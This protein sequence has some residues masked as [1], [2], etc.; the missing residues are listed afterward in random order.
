MRMNTC[1]RAIL[2]GFEALVTVATFPAVCA[3]ADKT[4]LDGTAWTLT[5]LADRALVPGATVTLR[6]E[7]GR[8]LGSDGCNR[9]TAP[10]SISGSTLQ[11]GPN[12]AS[13]QMACPPPLMQQAEAFANAL[14]RTRSYRIA[15][16]KLDLLTADGAATATF[17]AQSTTLAG[18]AWLVTGYNNGKQA[19]VSV[20][21]D[22]S[23]TMAFSSDGKV[24]GSAGCN[25][26][27]A[28]CAFD[29]AKLTISPA[30]TTRKMCAQLERIMEQEQQ[31]LKALESVATARFEGDRLEL[32]T[33]DGALAMTLEREA[34]QR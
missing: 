13:T 27:T 31:F 2:V 20:L 23:L 12:G 29:G 24:T 7:G 1:I 9:Y 33:A 22:T 8:A 30:T 10:Y 11:I 21:A 17:A 28:G 34:P 32:R 26:Y 16:G 14:S 4:D 5:A 15:A 25:R 18:T 6:F 3:A 19:V